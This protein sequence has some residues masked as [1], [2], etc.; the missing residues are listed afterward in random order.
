MSLNCRPTI[1]WR[2]IVGIACVLALSTA[3]AAWGGS[4]DIHNLPLNGRA[5]LKSKLRLSIDTRW[6]DGTGYRPI[7]IEAIPTPGPAS[8]DRQ[9]R[10]VL[11]PMG[12]QAGSEVSTVIDIPQGSRSG[13]KVLPL[14]QD[15]LWHNISVKVFEGDSRIEELSADYLNFSRTN[16]FNWTESSPAALFIDSDVPPRLQRTAAV[17]T[18]RSTAQD[19]KPTYDLP[20]Y[21]NFVRIFPESTYANMLVVGDGSQ[22]IGDIDLLSQL[23]D[24]PRAD[25]LPPGELPQKWLELTSADIVFVSQPD[26]EKLAKEHP[27]QFEAV[28]DWLQAGAILCVY[29][30][31]SKFER[32]PDLEKQLKL[33]K[34]PEIPGQA[35]NYRGWIEPNWQRQLADLPQ[36]V[37][38]Q[39]YGS[40]YATTANAQMDAS[41]PGSVDLSGGQ[42]PPETWPFLVREAG[43]GYVVAIGKENPF[44]G[45]R[46]FWVWMLNSVPD[47]HWMWYRRHGMSMH[48]TNDDFW[49]FLIPGVGV[50]PVVSFLLLITLFAAIIGPVNYIFLGRWQRLYLLLITVPLGAAIVTGSLFLYALATDGLGVRARIRSFTELDAR[51]GHAVSWSRQSYYASIAPSK[52]LTFPEDAA[53]YPL[54]HEPTTRTGQRSWNHR[55]DWNNGQHLRAGYLPSRSATQFLVVRSAPTQSR[56]LIQRQADNAPPKVKNELGVDIDYLIVADHQTLAGGKKSEQPNDDESAANVAGDAKTTPENSPDFPF[57]IPRTYWKIESLKAGAIAQAKVVPVAEVRK[58]LNAVYHDNAPAYPKNY[59]PTL[60]NNAMEFLFNDFPRYA[61][62]DTT[63][64]EPSFAKGVLERQ[65]SR[66]GRKSDAILQ[67]GTFLAITKSPTEV[68]LGVDG[69]KQD[70]SLHVVHGRWGDK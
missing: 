50:A 11:S 57:E 55:L 17:N 6:L 30:V 33:S 21:R 14:P 16:Y 56:L 15:E 51:T 64:E 38:I 62:V 24:V 20:D 31:G 23:N 37:N 70:R 3:T 8:Y 28:R 42:P 53:V 63:S 36:L 66:L 4:G 40:A 12:S 60:H 7:V 22:K 54:V 58:H 39:N 68:P 5:R 43:L 27:Q 65:L 69:M 48:R 19:P 59:D 13:V 67:P 49:N 41:Y 32:L 46:Q 52:G 26:L 35:K 47:N 34:K 61:S 9:I 29:E 10:V 18:F 1:N 44:P 25:L 45:E 2:R